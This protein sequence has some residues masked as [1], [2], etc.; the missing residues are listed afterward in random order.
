MSTEM[1]VYRYQYSAQARSLDESSKEKV[2]QN[3][4]LST[5][6]EVQLRGPGG[7]KTRTL[8]IDKDGL[9]YVQVGSADNVDETPLRTHIRRFNLS[10]I[11]PGG[12]DWY[13]GEV[14]AYGLRNTVA[15][16]FDQNGD[17]WGVDMGAD[18]LARKDIGLDY[19]N[20]PA[21]EFHKFDLK[22][23]M[24]GFYGYPW[25]FS[26]FNGTEA[27]LT[28]PAVQYAWPIANDKEHDDAWCQN[29]KNNIPATLGLQPHG[30]SL[31]MAFSAGKMFDASSAFVALHG[32]W[33]KDEPDGYKVIQIPI[34][35]GM[36]TEV[37]DFL[38]STT[39]DPTKWKVR[40]VD[41]T[42]GPD[43]AMYVTVDAKCSWMKMD[44]WNANMASCQ[45]GVILRVQYAAACSSNSD[46]RFGT[47]HAV[48]PKRRLLFGG[49]A[50]G[51]CK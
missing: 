15:M 45:K 25:C 4:H 31:G 11:P 48:G 39:D 12:L 13:T 36:P 38:K 40:P 42:F 10:S 28:I 1:S 37:K 34:K 3:I 51:V 22:N 7:H 19:N 8:E 30:A 49:S 23:N 2:V 43:G 5:N 9:L 35:D 32:S 41:V 21:E 44:A 20:G 26:H 6:E 14:V 46:C 16:K 29:P 33:N 18:N 24:G 27:P 17:F 47:C 50:R